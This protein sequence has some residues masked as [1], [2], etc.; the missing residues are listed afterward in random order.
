[1]GLCFYTLGDYF[2]EENMS[3]TL[4]SSFASEAAYTKACI[5]LFTYH[6]RTGEKRFAES[7]ELN[8][9]GKIADIVFH[10]A[11]EPSLIQKPFR[12]LDALLKTTTRLAQA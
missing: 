3:S 10:G 12:C 1:M 4:F 11:E 8:I 7:T 9:A 6:H 2:L 5:G